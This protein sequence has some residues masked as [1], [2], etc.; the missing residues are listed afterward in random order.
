[1]AQMPTLDDTNGATTA[2]VLFG[3]TFWGL[4][5]GAWKM[6]TGTLPT[7]TLSTAGTMVNAGYYAA[8]TLDTVDTDLAAGNIKSGTTIFGVAGTYAGSGGTTSAP[9]P[10]AKTG[11]GATC[12]TVRR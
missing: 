5:S 1:M 10:V 8:T 4:T 12:Y 2:D 11:A 9:F 3:K 7:Q 6:Q